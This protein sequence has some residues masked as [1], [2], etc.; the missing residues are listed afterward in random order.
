MGEEHARGHCSATVVKVL[1]IGNQ[2]VVQR[3]VLAKIRTGVRRHQWSSQTRAMVAQSDEEGEKAFTCVEVKGTGS[4]R[5]L[6]KSGTEGLTNSD[7][8]V[9][10][11]ACHAQSNDGQ[12]Y[13][14]EEKFNRRPVKVLRDT[15]CTGMIVDRAVV[16][17]VMVIPG[18][19]QMVDHTLMDVPLAS[20]T[21]KDTAG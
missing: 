5:N 16:P 20:R 6:K 17:D 12:T 8:V 4:K 1:D 18:S 10:I 15:G 11:A 14:G 21:T 9:Y 7:R 19:L 13:I 2:S 3:L